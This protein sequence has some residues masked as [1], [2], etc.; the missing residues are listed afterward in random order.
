MTA[1]GAGTAARMAL[2]DGGLGDVRSVYHV[3]V[4]EGPAFVAACDPNL[5]LDVESERS[6]SAT[7]AGMRCRR[8]ACAARWGHRR[9]GE[10]AP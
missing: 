5:L 6:A 3:V 9:G 7:S 8:P 1:A 2:R 4:V 10:S